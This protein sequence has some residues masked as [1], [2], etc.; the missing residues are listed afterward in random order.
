MPKAILGALGALFATPLLATALFATALVAAG[1]TPAGPA[2]AQ[3]RI[4][5]IELT[6]KLVPSPVKVSVLLPAGR[7]PAQEL[8]LLLML[9]GGGGDNGFLTQMR[10]TIEAA[11][12]A[13][14]F[15]PAAVATPDVGRSL[16]MDFKDGSQKWETF[17]VTELVP[18]LRRRYGLDARREATVVSGISMGG[19]G[20]L[21]LGLNHP[22]VF[23]GLAALEAGIEPAL[24]FDAVKMRNRFQRDDAFFRKVFGDP[25]DTAL[26]R[27][28]NP[29][30]MVIA[31]RQAILDTGL[32]IYVEA[33]DRDMFNLHEGVEFLH[34]VMWDHDVPHEYRLV[35][36][37]D[38]LGRTIPPRV[39]DG[40]RFLDRQV[41]RPPPPDDSF[42]RQTAMIT[43][44]R[45]A[46]GVPDDEPRPP[47]PP[48]SA[49]T[50]AR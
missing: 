48:T 5:T 24:D 25:V 46:A 20:A 38:H 43:R 27:R 8:P 37:A 28:S 16:Y 35:R 33:G 3:S 40:L 26:W 42:A 45:R 21:R 11:W 30:N 29:A 6:S 32:Q 1:F 7:T 2:H 13:G 4:E 18:E 17:I 44:M 34:R 39:R 9:H 36:G 19:L 22:Q 15:P 12:A 23:G 41:L 47:L 49:P 14:D 31:N 10:P 50:E